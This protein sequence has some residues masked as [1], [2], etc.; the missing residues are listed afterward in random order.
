MLYVYAISESPQLAEAVGL[1]GSP[2]RAIGDRS[3]YA[4]ASEHQELPPQPSERDLWRHELVVEGAMDAGA[5]LP[6][7]FGATLADEAGLRRLLDERGREFTRLL[8]SVRGAVELGV[9]A[10]LTSP[11]RARDGTADDEL[12]DASGPGTTYLLGVRARERRFGAAIA[13]VHEP[14]AALARRSALGSRHRAGA[15]MKA[16]YLVERDLV[17]AFRARVDGLALELDA[18]ISCTGPWPPYSFSMEAPE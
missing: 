17:N 4:V 12:T 7:R 9:R 8:E 18:N 15:A 5:V 13:Q 2:V 14:L 11:R 3:P 10:R 6:L 1:H 16:A